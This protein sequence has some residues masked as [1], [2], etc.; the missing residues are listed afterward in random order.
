MNPKPFPLRP[1]WVALATSALIAACGGG[2]AEAPPT[3]QSITFNP[4][5]TANVGTPVSLSAS[6]SSGLAVT[7]TTSSPSVCTVSGAT[8]TLIGTGTCTV[9]ADQAGNSTF[10][11]ATRVTRQITVNSAAITLA[12]GFGNGTLPNGG[13][14]GN[15]AAW[16]RWGEIGP[17]MA[18]FGG[19][20]W[21]EASPVIEGGYVY[22]GAYGSTPVTE[23]YLGL[24]MR[25]TNPVTL[26]GQTSLNIPLAIGGEWAQQNTNKSLDIVV[27]NAWNNA[28]NCANKVKAT[29]SGIT[30]TLTS[31]RIPLSQF[32]AVPEG[33]CTQT[34]QQTLAAPIA[35]VHVQAVFPNFNTTQ[36]NGDSVYPT[37]F[38]IG[39][40]VK[41]E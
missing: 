32:T 10:A 4:G 31:I 15:Y 29:I 17:V 13:T 7:F 12:S 14:W 30:A 19:G 3:A 37:A 16:E 5:A 18:G 21:Q 39:S 24:F 6:A 25:P 34:A 22:F 1:S 20:G 41:F 11:A 36:R 27:Q 9:N 35:E 33:A 23:G 28:G 26:N 2:S 40:P 38:T 8:L